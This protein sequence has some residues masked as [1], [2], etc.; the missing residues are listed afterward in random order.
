MKN[1]MDK[2]TIKKEGF[3]IQTP[4]PKPGVDPMFERGPETPSPLTSEQKEYWKIFTTELTN[5]TGYLFKLERVISKSTNCQISIVNTIESYLKSV[6]IYQD[7]SKDGDKLNP[8]TVIQ[9][10]T[11]DGDK[12]EKLGKFPFRNSVEEFA[13]E[14]TNI[15]ETILDKVI[16]EEEAKSKK[17]QQF[18]AVVD[19]MRKGNIE[20]K[21]EAGKVAK[22][23]I[24]NKD[25][26]DFVHTKTKNLPNKMKKESNK[27]KAKI[28]LLKEKL[29]KLTNK[30]V[31]LEEALKRVG[32]DE[33][34]QILAAQ[35][36][37]T[38]VTL[39]TITP[40]GMNKNIVDENGQKVVNPYYDKV[41]KENYVDGI[42]NYD[43][44]HEQ[45]SA[46]LA[47]GEKANFV[48]TG[49]SAGEHEGALVR[50]SGEP[51]LIMIVK[52]TSKPIYKVNGNVISKEELKPYLK[53]STGFAPSKGA[54]VRQYKISNIKSIVIGN[55]EYQII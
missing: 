6:I 40:V 19:Q 46:R 37:D 16:L 54:V 42:V 24:T 28:A 12:I 21:G 9:I 1:I 22:S 36:K 11:E 13:G 5:K 7:W 23:D 30:K 43:Y 15:I 47:A 51:K 2:K 29:E 34:E 26:S 39:F 50:N 48:P 32:I 41:V 35:P 4:S 49:K 33:L 20:P 8:I 53:P 14:I 3:A 10:E 38:P 44:T 52:D 55:D 17:Q 27:D 31:V 45:N 25:I 18:F